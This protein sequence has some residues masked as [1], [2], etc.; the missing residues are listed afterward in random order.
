[1]A[2]KAR[3]SAIAKELG[4]SS[5]DVIAKLQELGEFV[6]SPSSTIEAPVV[7]KLRAAFPA[8]AGGSGAASAP[9]PAPTNGSANGSA[10]ISERDG[11][12]GSSGGA[13]N[14]ASRP[15]GR[16]GAPVVAESVPAPVA[17]AP[18]ATAS[19]PAAPTP[20]APTAPA[21]VAKAPEA[22]APAP[23]SPQVARPDVRPPAATVASPVAPAASA[24]AP[25]AEAPPRPRPTGGVPGAPRP[26]RVGNNPFGVGPGARAAAPR[27]GSP[28][29][30][31]CASAAGIRTSG[32][33][34]CPRHA[35]SSWCPSRGSRRSTPR[36]PRRSAADTRC[37][38]WSS[39]HRRS[40]PPGPARRGR[41]G[42]DRRLPRRRSRRRRRRWPSRWGWRRWCWWPRPWHR[43]RRVRSPGRTG[44]QGPQVAQAAAPGVRQHAGAVDRRRD[45]AAR[46]R[47]GRPARRVALRCPTSPTRSTPTPAR[48]CRRCSTWARW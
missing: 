4:Q 19:A 36:H 29:R 22:P 18:S 8:A 17:S 34:R 20:V 33:P 39:R 15:A 6:K 41:A 7:R 38:G 2:G 1:M 13:G 27:P 25:A 14:Q 3:V 9:A 10:A 46:Q 48:W 16:P 45:A 32:R 24:D 12:A 35:A 28:V 26:P 11:S 21:A 47:P 30:A 40:L 23:S 44:P 42:L 31:R 43:G 5:K 37:A